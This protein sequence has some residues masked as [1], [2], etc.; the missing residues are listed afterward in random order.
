MCVGA[1]QFVEAGHGVG[2]GSSRRFG[3]LRHHGAALLRS[4]WVLLKEQAVSI[5]TTM[6]IQDKLSVHATPACT[7]FRSRSTGYDREAMFRVRRR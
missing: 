5:G 6:A 7:E 3:G 1:Y 4:G 2:W